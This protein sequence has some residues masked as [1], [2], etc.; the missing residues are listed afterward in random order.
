MVQDRFDQVALAQI[1]L[2]F[3]ENLAVDRREIGF[4]IVDFEL[5]V[6]KKLHRP[7][8][9]ADTATNRFIEQGVG[10]KTLFQQVDAFENR[11]ILNEKFDGV[12][13]GQHAGHCLPVFGIGQQP[14]GVIRSE[15]AEIKRR[16]YSILM[17]EPES[18]RT[19][20]REKNIDD[21][22]VRM[23]WDAWQKVSA[24]FVSAVYGYTPGTQ[25][26]HKNLIF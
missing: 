12:V 26:T 2:G 16:A 4:G 25:I 23:N 19:I 7:K 18:L 9:A 22:S 15:S 11:R 24:G 20:W 21:E 5:V 13:W 10:V 1:D 6:E 3:P 14:L 8:F 17:A